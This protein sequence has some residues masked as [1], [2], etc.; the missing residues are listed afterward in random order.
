VRPDWGLKFLDL[1][2]EVLLTK[3]KQHP[4]LRSVLLHTGDARIV[5]EQ[6]HDDF[7]GSGGRNELGKALVRVRER[8]RAESL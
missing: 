8:L 3:C 7:W 5:Y 6:P 2:D 4:D 1:M